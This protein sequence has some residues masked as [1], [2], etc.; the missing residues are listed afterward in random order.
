VDLIVGRSGMVL[1]LETEAM[2]DTPATAWKL[3]RARVQD[4]YDW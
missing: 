2:T 4:L 1:R 3:V